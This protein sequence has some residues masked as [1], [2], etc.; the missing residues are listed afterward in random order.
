MDLS[1]RSRH[2]W[3]K[4][5]EVREVDGVAVALGVVLVYGVDGVVCGCVGR[6]SRR[7][8]TLAL[9]W[10]WPVLEEAGERGRCARPEGKMEA[11]LGI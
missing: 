8:T 7:A 3:W 2:L 4:S 10:R 9:P 5:R 1:R 6:S 11:A